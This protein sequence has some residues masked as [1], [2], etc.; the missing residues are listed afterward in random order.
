MVIIEPYDLWLRYCPKLMFI[1]L[2]VA[3]SDLKLIMTRQSPVLSLNFACFER[4]IR[5]SA[6]DLISRFLH[7]KM[8]FDLWLWRETR[9]RRVVTPKLW[10]LTPEERA[11]KRRCECRNRWL[12]LVCVLWWRWKLWRLVDMDGS[13]LW[14]LVG[15]YGSKIWR[16]R[17]MNRRTKM[18]IFTIFL[19]IHVN[20]PFLV[21]FTQK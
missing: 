14:S 8:S 18:I 11:F 4:V 5:I 20:H 12:V 2:C 15:W 9:V 13:E 16:T 3:N 21:G 19:Q 6:L 17:C 1:F 10:L 7:L